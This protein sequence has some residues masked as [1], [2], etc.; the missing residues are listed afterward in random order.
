MTAT[1]ACCVA[2]S[3]SLY[4]PT[5]SSLS[6]SAFTASIRVRSVCTPIID[7]C[8]HSPPLPPLSLS[9]PVLVLHL[10]PV[11]RQKA[12]NRGQRTTSHR[13]FTSP[14]RPH[15]IFSRC[16]FSHSRFSRNLVSAE[17]FSPRFNAHLHIKIKIISRLSTGRPI[18]RRRR[19]TRGL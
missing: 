6:P 13:R 15:T 16:E 5:L 10:F 12:V 8:R 18:E 4:F 17:I 14:S 1:F 19:R 2:L 3:P 9:P 11:K 7:F